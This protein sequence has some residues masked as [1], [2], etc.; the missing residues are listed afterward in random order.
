MRYE[1]RRTTRRHHD[2]INASFTAED[3]KQAWKARKVGRVWSERYFL[4]FPAFPVLQ[5]FPACPSVQHSI[6]E[7][8]VRRP[9]AKDPVDGTIGE[10]H[11]P[12]VAAPGS[13]ASAVPGFRPLRGDRSCPAHVGLLY[14][15]GSQTMT[16]WPL[17]TIEA[18]SVGRSLTVRFVFPPRA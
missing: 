11:V 3:T 4:T 12:L 5:T 8:T 18:L 16:C 7:P 14:T 6:N 13:A 10:R 15:L 2:P 1:A 9:I 17:T